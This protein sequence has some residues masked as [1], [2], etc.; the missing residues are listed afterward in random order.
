MSRAEKVALFRSLFVGRE[1]VY[2]LRWENA[3]TRKVGWLPAVKGGWANAR[4]PGREHLPLTDDVIESHLAGRESVGLYP[5]LRGDARRLLVCDFDGASWTLDALAYINVI[6]GYWHDPAADAASFVDGW[7]RSGDLGYL[8]DDELL[9]VVD[10]LKDVII[11]GGQNIYCAEVEAVI[12]AC[13]GVHDAAVLGLPHPDLG[14]QVAAVVVVSEGDGHDTN[15][16]SLR[17]QLRRL[18]AAYK[19]PTVLVVRVNPLPRTATGKV[20]KRQLRDE[21]CA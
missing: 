20:L 19:V 18:L 2:A 21:L 14:E 3:S 17:A 5:L 13:P 8:D 6:R 1:D 9:F 15:A 7:F 12:L 11:R 16:E 10:R 4:K